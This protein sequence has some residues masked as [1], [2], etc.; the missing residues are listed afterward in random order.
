MGKGAVT[1]NDAKGWYSPPFTD[2]REEALRKGLGK[3]LPKSQKEL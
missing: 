1:R 3:R 2:E